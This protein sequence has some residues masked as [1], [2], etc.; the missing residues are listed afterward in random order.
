MTEG[1]LLR[2]IPLNTR[3]EVG[4]SIVSKFARLWLE[5]LHDLLSHLPA[6]HEDRTKLYP[7]GETLPCMT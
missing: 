3:L 5:N 6:R 4:P 7:I 2:V 1:C